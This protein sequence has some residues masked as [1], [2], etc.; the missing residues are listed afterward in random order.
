MSTEQNW[1][2]SGTSPPKDGRCTGARKDGRPCGAPAYGHP[3]CVQH[4]SSLEDRRRW[5]IQGASVTHRRQLVKKLAEAGEIDKALNLPD[6]STSE[7]VEAFIA[8]LVAEVHAGLLPPSLANS[9][10]SLLQVRL[11]LAEMQV[12]KQLADI[13]AELRGQA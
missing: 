7:K 8:R 11:R 1:T 3:L 6:L 5:A 13:E 12:A 2:Q 9:I 4:R 10:T